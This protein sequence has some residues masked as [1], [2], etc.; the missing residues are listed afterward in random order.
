MPTLP[1]QLKGHRVKNLINLF[2]ETKDQHP[3]R[4]EMSQKIQYRN[5]NDKNIL[6]ISFIS[7]VRVLCTSES[8][9]ERGP[10]NI[11]GEK[12][13]KD[14]ASSKNLIS[15]IGAEASPK[16]GDAT[17]C[18]LGVR[19]PCWHAC[20]TRCKCLMETTHNLLKDKVY[21]NV[22]ELVESLIGWEVTVGQWS[23]WHLTYVRGKF[24][25]AE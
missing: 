18:P 5:I 6:I 23:E 2:L 21:I 22:T 12:S 15:T 9:V 13:S 25:I 7:F 19:V 16:M 17:R 10:T 11:R 20:H 8:K 4:A 3:F 14:M 24:H 1:H